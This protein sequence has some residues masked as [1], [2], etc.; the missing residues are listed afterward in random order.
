[1]AKAPLLVAATHPVQSARDVME[2]WKP[3]QAV[4]SV[5]KQTE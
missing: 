4:S 1:V 5:L 3:E 2:A